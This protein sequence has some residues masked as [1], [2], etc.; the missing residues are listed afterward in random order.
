MRYWWVNQNQTFRQEVDGG[1]MWS[2]KRNTN[3]RRNPFYE[4]MREVS[5]GDVVFSFYDTR[6][7]ALGIVTGYC[8]ESPKPEEFG[9]AGTNWSQIGWRVNVQWQRLAIPVRPKDHMDRLRPELPAQYSPLLPNGNGLQSVY[10]TAVNPGLAAALRALIGAEASKVA[11]VAKEVGQAERDSPAPDWDIDEWERRVEQEI[12]TNTAIPETERTA[13]VQARRGQGR[14]RD[15]V[16]AIERACRIT[17][18]ERREHLIAS[19]IKPWRRSDNS[20]R[21]DGENGLLLTPTVDHLFD[22]GFISFENDGRVIVSPV[23]D[24]VSLQRMGVDPERKINVGS[25]SAG[26]RGNLDF[27]R[28]QVLRMVRVGR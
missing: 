18:V 24:P 27:H 15:N 9:H 28:E 17:R 25:F 20:Q 7:A 3:D 22:K 23:A 21:L 13:L 5:P 16:N 6:I 26:Q 8:H 19:H 12:D 10:L 1:Y 2:P 11:D 4:F 14:F